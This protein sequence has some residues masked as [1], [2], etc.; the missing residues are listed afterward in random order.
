[1]SEED[2]NSLV[3]REEPIPLIQ[4][5]TETNGKLFYILRIQDK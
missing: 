2:K 1:M 4:L 5:N 3:F